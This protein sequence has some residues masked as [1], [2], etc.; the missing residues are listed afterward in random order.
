M[1]IQPKVEVGPDKPGIPVREYCD[2]LKVSKTIFES[3][4]DFYDK[5]SVSKW[6]RGQIPA[7]VAAAS[8]FNACRWETEFELSYLCYKLDIPMDQVVHALWAVGTCFRK[9]NPLPG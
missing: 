9:S 1:P 5:V 3:A 8:I 7:A 6:Y 4:K 2:R